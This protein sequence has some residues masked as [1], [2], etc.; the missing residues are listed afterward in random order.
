M[1]TLSPENS[2]RLETTEGISAYFVLF[3][4][5][6]ALTLVLSKLLHDLPTLNVVFPEAG[7][8]LLV[9]VV[10]G[11]FVNLVVA[12]TKSNDYVSNDESV[13]QSLL[14]F[15]PQI[16]FIALLP[17]IIFNSGYHLRRELFFRHIV[18]ITLFAV[19]GTLISALSISFLLQ[20]VK[21]LG[22]TGGFAPSKLTVAIYELFATTFRST[23]LLL[24]SSV[25]GVAR[26]WGTDFSD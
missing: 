20:V 5:L 15:S 26:L 11:F 16:F 18:P 10:A 19:L 21:S 1:T 2:S 13:A 7:M 24:I 14:S 8:V 23:P 25:Y 6:L 17:P 3:L 4:S 12:R 22:F 9:G